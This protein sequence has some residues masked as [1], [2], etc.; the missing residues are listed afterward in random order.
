MAATSICAPVH[1]AIS[2]PSVGMPSKA[3]AVANLSPVPPDLPRPL[4]P[5]PAGIRAAEAGGA[6]Q[7]CRVP[8][9]AAAAG[10]GRL[11]AGRRAAGSRRA[12]AARRQLTC[13][14]INGMG[15]PEKQ[16][17]VALPPSFCCAATC[18]AWQRSKMLCDMRCSAINW[19]RT[20]GV[21]ARRVLEQHAFGFGGWLACALQACEC[22]FAVCGIQQSRVDRPLPSSGPWGL[23]IDAGA[24]CRLAAATKEQA[25]CPVCTLPY[26][27]HIL[28]MRRAA[29][30]VLQAARQAAGCAPALSTQP[31]ALPALRSAAG[32]CTATRTRAP[33][34]QRPGWVVGSF[35][36]QASRPDGSAAPAAGAAGHAHVRW[37]HCSCSGDLSLPPPQKVRPPLP[38][39]LPAVARVLQRLIV[40]SCGL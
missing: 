25:H 35:G 18:N 11:A 22:L 39:G 12:A 13:A 28:K 5:P 19:Q 32:K 16:P 23:V 24:G 40:K 10:A 34:L 36:A 20:R 9:H 8:G 26:R 21:R 2:N 30:L 7:H 29:Q 33:G 3:R 1:T 15:Q 31:A 37:S 17:N 14:S 4:C 6:A 38:T 27:L